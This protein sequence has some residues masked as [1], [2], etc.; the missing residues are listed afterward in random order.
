MKCQNCGAT[1]PED[2]IF[3]PYCGT[4][5]KDINA[6]QPK[7]EEKKDKNTN[8]NEEILKEM[9]CPNC[10][11]PLNP[12]PGESIVVCSYCGT[13]IFL[14]PNGGWAKVKKHLILDIM[15]PNSEKALNILHDYMDS[16]ILHR[17]RFE[18]STILSTNLLYVPYW[19]VKASYIANFVYMKTE[20]QSFGGRTVV[21]EIPMP[22]MESG[23]VYIPIIGISNLKEFQPEDYEFTIIKAREIRES[24]V[25]GSVKLMNG[26]IKVDA[27][28]NNKNNYVINF[29]NRKIRK[30]YKKIQS[31]SINPNVEEIFILHAPIWKFE[32][33]FPGLMK[34][35]NHKEVI[36][37]DGSNGMIME[38]IKEE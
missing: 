25:S 13:T 30:R 4:K 15:V 6:S 7:Q 5:I 9:K 27:I 37:M 17:H 22:G 20:V 29:V 24:D 14:N 8:N 26:D 12:L 19:I 11:A 10:G 16:S 1:V 28:E 23:E 35:T 33:E 21:Q 36:L 18:K 3:C 31:I 32:I 2:V 34:K 38:K